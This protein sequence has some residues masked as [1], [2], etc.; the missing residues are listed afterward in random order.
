[1]DG[2]RLLRRP[3]H[4]NALCDRQQI[5]LCPEDE[6]QRGGAAVKLLGIEYDHPEIDSRCDVSRRN[7]FTILPREKSDP[8]INESQP[9]P[10]ESHSTRSRWSKTLR[11]S[12]WIVCP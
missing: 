10:K 8:V 7:D 12:C 3:G 2:Q 1:M 5:A 4:A 6:R 9:S 11:V